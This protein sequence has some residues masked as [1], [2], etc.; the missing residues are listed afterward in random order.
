MDSPL[1]WAFSSLIVFRRV[2]FARNSILDKTGYSL[3]DGFEVLRVRNL[4]LVGV[5]R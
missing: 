1:F 4:T 3:P 2:C 5:D